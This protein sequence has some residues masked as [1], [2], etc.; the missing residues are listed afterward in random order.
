MDLF[1][2]AALLAFLLCLSLSLFALLISSK[3]L[4]SVVGLFNFAVSLWGLGC[5]LAGFWNE[6][7]LSLRGWRIAH[8]GGY[9]IPICF[10]HIVILFCLSPYFVSLWPLCGLFKIAV[11]IAP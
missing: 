7:N 11:L 5:F 2:L 4:Y 8:V 10:Y 9:F 1:T 6:P 3:K